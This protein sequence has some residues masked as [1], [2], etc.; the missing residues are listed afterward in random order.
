MLSFIHAADIHL[1]SP[2]RNL[3]SYEGAPVAAIRGATRKAFDRLV[4]EAVNRTVDLLLIAGDL[5][6]G[7]WQDYNTGLYF[8]ARMTRLKEAGIPV[9]IIA[10]NHDAASRMSR[11]LTLPDNVHLFPADR[12]HTILLE[13]PGVA[14]HGQG[15][16][17]PAVK[18]NLVVR[19]PD[20]VAGYFNI[21]ML[22]TCLTGREG[23]ESYAP[24]S[25]D[26]LLARGYQ[27]WA[28]GHVH[29]RESLCDDPPVIFPGNLQGRHIRETGPKGCMLVSAEDGST[30]RVDF[31]RLDRI[32]WE[33]IEVDIGHAADGYDALT[34]ACDA[35]LRR[36]EENGGRPL[37]VRLVFF[38][39]SAAHD[40]LSSDPERWINQ[41]RLD[42]LEAGGGAVWVESVVNGTA[43]PIDPSAGMDGPIGELSDIIGHAASDPSLVSAMGHAVSDLL[44]KLPKEVRDAL[45]VPA[46][47]DPSWP[48]WLETLA[49]G[50]R[51]MLLSRLMGRDQ[52]R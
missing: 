49:R 33:R 36:L 1:D 27:Y 21:G 46:A 41:L 50:V 11:T 3:A 28:L 38:G 14:V 13:K 32:R 31:L 12:P 18:K 6:D 17:T 48:L 45:D 39:R 25:L 2:L 52:E 51:P 40:A 15:F 10:G 16:S 23:H 44:K 37:A 29:Q 19:Y 8:A 5:Y 30:P 42:L 34:A 26:D 24:C 4:D 20:A 22:H 47:D 7:D 9:C 43:P 35:T